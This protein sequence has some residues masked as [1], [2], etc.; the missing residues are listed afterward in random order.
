[1]G[2]SLDG[3]ELGRGVTQQKDGYY[4][5]RFTNSKGIR[6]SKRFK[7]LLACQQW[8]AEETHKDN[9]SSIIKPYEMVVDEWFQTWIQMKGASIRSR[10][11][12]GLVRNYKLHIHPVIG[13][14]K[15]GSVR[16]AHCQEICNYMGQTGKKSST[17]GVIKSIMHDMFQSAYE[18][19]LIPKNPCGRSVKVNVGED[20]EARDAMTLKEHEKFL[21]GMRGSK[22]EIP[23]RFALQTGLRIGELTGLQ[24]NDIDWENNIINVK[25]S[26]WKDWKTKEWIVDK[27][28]TKSSMR[29]IP[30]TAEA[31]WLLKEQKRR[32]D[33]IKIFKL[34]WSEFIFLNKVGEPIDVSTYNYHMKV[35]CEKIGIRKMS[36]HILRHT[37]AT[38][39]IENGMKP[40]TLQ[41][42]LGHRSIQTTL[43]CY[44][45]VTNIEKQKEM[46]LVENAL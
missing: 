7:D 36:M 5:A 23:V 25:R 33:E 30:L 31:K 24:W 3:K 15:I 39:C 11:K 9:R 21:E 18:N 12:E 27:T 37:F 45:T 17:V 10:T 20:S 43:N 1:M 22:V 28:K 6:V 4:S 40:K 38:R 42:I 19:D 8:I 46:F 44:V 13:S 34:Q 41:S 16:L 14:M 35:I 29:T 2:K 26:M 32:N